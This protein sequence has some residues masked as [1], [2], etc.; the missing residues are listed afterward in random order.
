MKE[1]GVLE[2]EMKVK[3]KPVKEVLEVSEA[4]NSKMDG[5]DGKQRGEGQLE[6]EVA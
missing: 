3:G 4:S 6:P 1:K 5:C 2:S